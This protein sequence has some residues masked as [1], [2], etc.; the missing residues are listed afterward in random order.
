MARVLIGYRYRLKEYLKNQGGMSRTLKCSDEDDDDGKIVVVKLLEKPNSSDSDLPK[1][2]FQREVESLKMVS[3]HPNVV[4]ILDSGFDEEW[5]DGQG[6]YYIVLE[7]IKGNNL[8]EKN[9]DGSIAEWDTLE[10]LDIIRQLLE[11]MNYI[12]SV[13][14]IHRDIKPAN[15][16]VQSEDAQVKIIDFG[17]SK[18]EHE[19]Y[20]DYTTSGYLTE[21][22]SSPEQKRGEPVTRQSDIYSLGIV[23]YELLSGEKIEAGKPLAMDSFDEDIKQVIIKMTNP[24]LEQRYKSIMDVKTAFNQIRRKKLPERYLLVNIHKAIY[25]QMYNMG[26]VSSTNPYVLKNMLLKDFS[27]DFRISSNIV[28]DPDG[29]RHADGTYWL[30][31]RQWQ[32]HVTVN[33]FDPKRLFMISLG[34][35]DPTLLI[36]QKEKAIPFDND[37]RIVFDAGPIYDNY[38][39]VDIETL[40]LVIHSNEVEKASGRDQRQVEYAIVE[41]W[42]RILELGR[43]K[44]DDEKSSISHN[45]Q[46]I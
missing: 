40:S 1:Q 32:A 28:T 16:M 7:F 14:V 45:F 46:G 36:R 20:S 25:Q 21:L 12:H 3:N 19:F 27:E 30:Y 10:R 18:V 23:F 43:K 8:K 26:V 31:G 6:A 13:G 15:I 34:T 37:V 29:K 35:P 17:I 42:G 2:V 44:L 11:G 22:Y 33:K 9:Q 24:D 5:M 38:N 39:L 41:K 4:K